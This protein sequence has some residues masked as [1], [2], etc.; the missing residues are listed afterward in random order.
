MMVMMMM[1]MMIGVC[2]GEGRR[3]EMNLNHDKIIINSLRRS[4]L[5]ICFATVRSSSS[6]LPFC[7]TEFHSEVQRLREEGKKGGRGTGKVKEVSE[8]KGKGEK[9]ADVRKKGKKDDDDAADAAL[10]LV[11][12]PGA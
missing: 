1:A 3:G 12:S 4:N 11:R 8:R 10:R 9:D 7:L 2:E 6:F 5:Y